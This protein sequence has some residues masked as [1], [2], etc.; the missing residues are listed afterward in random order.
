M[1]IM[2][3]GEIILSKKALTNTSNAFRKQQKTFVRYTVCVI[4]C[5]PSILVAFRIYVVVFDNVRGILT[6]DS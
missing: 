3:K 6:H 5:S 4:N 2:P 1:N